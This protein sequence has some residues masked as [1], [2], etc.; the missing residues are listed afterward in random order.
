MELFGHPSF[1]NVPKQSTAKHT[2]YNDLVDAFLDG[3][4]Q[5]PFDLNPG[6]IGLAG[7][8]DSV[9]QNV[10][11]MFHTLMTAQVILMWTA[12]ESL[13]GDLWEDAVNAHPKTLAVG[14]SKLPDPKQNKGNK[15]PG[16]MIQ[17]HELDL[18]GYDV[19]KAMGTIL[20]ERRD[21]DKLSRIIETYGYTFPHPAKVNDESF[22]KNADLRAVC[23]IRNLLVHSAG[24]VDGDFIQQRG[25]DL[26]L[27]HYK[28][29]DKLRLEGDVVYELVMG[30][31]SFCNELI[32]DVDGWIAS[33]P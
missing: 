27:A 16:K 25:T 5:P 15:S 11:E 9:K 28:D 1:E 29:G 30:L 17:I 14:C 10:H 21:F 24:I 31:L 33:N 19:S 6:A 26:R 20:R 3:T 32:R 2:E 13:A 23:A 7:V 4:K 12:F 18:R 22:W 8:A